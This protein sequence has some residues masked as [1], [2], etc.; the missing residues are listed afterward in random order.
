[1]IGYRTPAFGGTGLGAADGCANR[2][3]AGEK[4]PIADRQADVASQ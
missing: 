4:A 1:M 2:L 3:E